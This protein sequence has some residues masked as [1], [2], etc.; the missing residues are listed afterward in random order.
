MERVPVTI[1]TGF[2]GAGKVQYGCLGLSRTDNFT[3]S[4]P[5]S[6]PWKAYC[7]YSK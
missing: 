1:I 6:K 3:E 7:C 4:Y 2:L 5:Y